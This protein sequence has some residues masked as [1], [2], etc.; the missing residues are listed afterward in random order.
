MV[1]SKYDQLEGA[2]PSWHY[3]VSLGEWKPGMTLTKI[4]LSQTGA[5]AGSLNQARPDNPCA[6]VFSA[7]QGCYVIG[8]SGPSTWTMSGPIPWM[9]LDPLIA[10]IH[11]LHLPHVNIK[12]STITLVDQGI[13]KS[14]YWNI[15]D[16]A[17]DIDHD[18]KIIHV[19]RAHS[20]M[21][22]VFQCIQTQDPLLVKDAWIKSYRDPEITLFESLTEDGP[23]PGWVNIKPPTEDRIHL[24]TPQLIGIT[25]RRK[26]RTVMENTGLPFDKCR[27]LSDAIAA[28]YDILEGKGQQYLSDKRF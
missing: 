14:P 15:R 13:S 12:D 20:R 16:A 25:Q 3:L 6:L 21:T 2:I 1:Q 17:F 7:C 22:T 23:P 26:D 4:E 18:F 10:Y 5:Y 19:G 28:T 11:S 8:Y 24:H 27:K 9:N